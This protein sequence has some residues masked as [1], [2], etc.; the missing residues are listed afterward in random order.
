[1]MQPSTQPQC[2]LV[3]GE[4]NVPFWASCI[5]RQCLVSNNTYSPFE[6]TSFAP[7]LKAAWLRAIG[8]SCQVGCHW[9]LLAIPSTRTS[10]LRFGPIAWVSEA[11]IKMALIPGG[12]V[13]K[14][15]DPSWLTLE[16]KQRSNFLA[17]KRGFQPLNHNKQKNKQSQRQPSHCIPVWQPAMWHPAR[18][19]S[20][21]WQY[22]QTPTVIQSILNL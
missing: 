20:T 14:G 16:G 17:V 21:R 10:L 15:L 19:P 3:G 5:W 9:E 22:L 12:Q 11:S 18:M 4:R 1:M 8:K 7:N 13:D 2:Q 6:E